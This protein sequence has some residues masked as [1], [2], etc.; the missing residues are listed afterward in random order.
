MT[1]GQLAFWLIRAG[2]FQAL[3]PGRLTVEWSDDE[4]AYL[5]SH[6]G[7]L[8][9]AHVATHLW[10][11]LN[12]VKQMA[13]R[14]DLASDMRE[15]VPLPDVAREAGV[16]TSTVHQWIDHH[17]Y[18]RHTRTWGGNLT[19]MP[20]PMVRQYLHAN[21]VSTR[22]P[23]WWG[24]ARAAETIGCTLPTLTT[25]NLTRR[26]HGRTDYYDPHEV[27]QMAQTYTNT[28]PRTYVRLRDVHRSE[29]RAGRL[30]HWLKTQGH[31]VHTYRHPSTNQQAT[32]TSADAARAFLSAKGHREDMVE[33]LLRKV[34]TMKASRVKDGQK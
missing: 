12:S 21:R 34:W 24:S 10:R 11:S 26:T 22:P 4:L 28:P 14:L 30:T 29:H 25:L 18:R 19:L 9:P 7:L 3:L 33:T 17:H 31:P 1:T 5:E 15:F 20:L 2:L 6:Y 16:R 13:T 23:G 27:Q 32:Y 8:G